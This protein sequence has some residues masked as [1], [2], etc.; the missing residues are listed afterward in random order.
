MSV[1]RTAADPFLQAVA[2]PHRCVLNVLG[3]P[4]HF[5]SNRRWLLQLAERAYGG[6]PALDPSSPVPRIRL[7]ANADLPRDALNVPPMPMVYGD[8][9]VFAVVMSGA[10]AGFGALSAG[11]GMVTVSPA[12]ARFPYN[13]RYELIEFVAYRLT[14]H[15]L[16]AVGM[17]AACVA[18]GDH[19]LILFGDSGAGKSTL[20]FALMQ[21]GWNL[22]AEDGLFVLPKCGFAL[23]GVPNFVHLMPDARVFFKR[24][25]RGGREIAR[26]SGRR[27]LEI[28]ARRMR[29]CPRVEAPLGRL[30]FIGSTG[31]C[32][33]PALRKIDRDQAQRLLV[34]QQPFAA[35]QADWPAALDALLAQPAYLLRRG[36][37]VRDSVRLLAESFD[38]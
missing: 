31:T 3:V 38:L 22:I 15:H 18:R 27:K 6:L 32:Q 4:V 19:S 30:I 7:I 20:V 26:R 21:A 8:G 2:T 9:D 11:R 28:D 34:R 24:Q 37:D 14:A 17:H 29:S 25:L 35:R 1:L 16:D 23:R 5:E 33:A 36:S 13:V 12:M 10:D